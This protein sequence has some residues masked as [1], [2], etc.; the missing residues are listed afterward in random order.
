MTIKKVRI[1]NYKSFEDVEVDLGRF[2]VLIGANA[3]GKTNFVEVFRFLR[4]I[5]DYGLE[6]A[7]SLQGGI[8]FLRNVKIGPSKNLSVKIVYDQ[9][10]TFQLSKGDRVLMIKL[11]EMIYEFAI[12]FND[13]GKD[14]EISK[15]EL[16]LKCGL[17]ELE[18]AEK[19]KERG[20]G[21][22]SISNIKGNIVFNQN[23]SEDDIFPNYMLEMIP[24]KTLLLETTPL[25]FVPPFKKIFGNIRVY[26]FERQLYKESTKITSKME[27]EEDGSNLA[28]VLQNILGNENEKRKFFNLIEDLLPFV[29]DLHVEKF[30]DKS[31]LFKMQEKYDSTYL[32]ASSL[33]IGTKIIIA[34]IIALY[35]EEKPLIVIEEPG[36]CLHPS[37]V[38]RIVTMMKEASEEKQI[39]ATTHNQEM[40]KYVDLEDLL[41][42]SRN[43]E[44]FSTIS[45]L[46]E[47]RG[48]KTFLE[49]EIGIE[50]LYVQNLLGV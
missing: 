13:S 23:L 1:S 33:S 15:D 44:G 38:S 36:M 32:P 10:S 2:N 50:E 14:F 45:R 4:D 18:P 21:E 48:V 12:E 3:S 22:I 34:L 25:F 30:A 5:A 49:N 11:Y 17:F 37:L 6:N 46:N 24:P 42:V 43:K 26:E 7:V 16:T 41:F 20:E 28:I 29:S 19:I 35:F 47:K 27:L 40:V 31:L 39:I 9:Q 8:E